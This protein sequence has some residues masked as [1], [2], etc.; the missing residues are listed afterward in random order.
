MPV[1]TYDFQN[2][3]RKVNDLQHQLELLNKD[4]ETLWNDTYTDQTIPPRAEPEEPP[5]PEQ[6]VQPNSS[7]S[8][9]D[10]AAQVK[11]KR[12]KT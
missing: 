3:C 2:L 4:I 12:L 5:T 6:S 11:G 8:K 10:K 1:S 9:E 7:A